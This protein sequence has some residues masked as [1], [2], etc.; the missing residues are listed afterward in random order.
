MVVIRLVLHCRDV[1]TILG[2]PG[3]ISGLYKAI[4]TML[5]E[6]CAL[7]SVG[8]LLVIGILGAGNSAVETFI[9]ILV[10]TQ[11]RSPL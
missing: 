7:F 10:E 8:S 5:V 3:G 4:I 11:V 2:A 1:R 6:S 9:P